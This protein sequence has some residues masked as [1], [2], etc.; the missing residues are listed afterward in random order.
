MA[1]EVRAMVLSTAVKRQKSRALPDISGRADL[2][3]GHEKGCPKAQ[4]FERR[5]S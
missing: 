3:W 1:V 4:R 5:V 2:I